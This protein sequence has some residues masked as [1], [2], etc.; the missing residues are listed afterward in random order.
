MTG[1]RQLELAARQVPNL[2]DSVGRSSGEPLVA[3]FD[4]DA[5][6]PAGV[7]GDDPEKFPRRVP[8]GLRHGR[9]LAR[10]QSLKREEGDSLELGL[11]TQDVQH[12]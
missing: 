6:N 2:D 3:G 5:T 11:Q 7:A 4:G 8:V 12:I 10:L 9:R 1:Q